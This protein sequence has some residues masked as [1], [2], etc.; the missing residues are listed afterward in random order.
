[1]TRFSPSWRK[2]NVPVAAIMLCLLALPSV[3]HFLEASMTRHMLVQF[4]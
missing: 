3:R 4:P 2:W 1:M